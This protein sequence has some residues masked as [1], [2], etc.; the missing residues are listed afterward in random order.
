MGNWFNNLYKS[1]VH[2]IGLPIVDGFL[3]LGFNTKTNP[4]IFKEFPNIHFLDLLK[5]L[6]SILEQEQKI[7]EQEQKV[8]TETK[9]QAIN[10]IISQTSSILDRDSQLKNIVNLVKNRFN[11]TQV[12]IYLLDENKRTLR[13][14]ASSGEAGSQL[15]NKG[16]VIDAYSEESPI[17]KVV[18][19]NLPIFIQEFSKQTEFEQFRDYFPFLIE[20]EISLPLQSGDEV[21]GVISLLSSHS[22][23]FKEEDTEIYFPLAN[24]IVNNLQFAKLYG[25]QKETAERLREVDHL[26]NEFLASMSHE[27][28]TPLNSIIGFADVLLEGIDGDLNDRQIEDITMIRDGGRHLRN[29]IGDILDMSKIEAG[30]MDLNYSEINIRQ[31]A[32]EVL[33]QIAKLISNKNIEL[34]LEIENDIDRIEADRTRLTQI[35]VNILSN[36]AKF[37]EEGSIIVAIEQKSREFLAISVSDTGIG[38]SE[39]DIGLT[40]ERFR[41]VGK[42][43]YQTGGTGLGLP[44]TK[45]LIELHGGKIWLESKIGVGTIVT[46]TLPKSRKNNINLS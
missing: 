10:E 34:R 27:L 23:W 8:T 12:N 18:R 30:M 37:T 15:V 5:R 4:S 7:L 21:F 25:E 44:I 26:K 33:I 24:Q 35:F 40:F 22:Y 36:A 32:E 31:L 17:G 38:I 13:L 1:K 9:L 20:S 2:Y 39:N 41:Q 45:N 19:S 14:A 11:L 6:L 42:L 43:Q 16:W 28:R 29:L 3:F 46:F